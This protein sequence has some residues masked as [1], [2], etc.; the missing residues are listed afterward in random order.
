MLIT[1]KQDGGIWV[2]VHTGQGSDEIVDLFGTHILPTPFTAN[3][4]GTVVQDAIRKLNPEH[5]VVWEDASTP[6]RMTADE[7]EISD[8]LGE[9]F[10]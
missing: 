4:L 8:E 2:G 9:I 10:G 5:T 3:V 1:L 6:Y 7:Q